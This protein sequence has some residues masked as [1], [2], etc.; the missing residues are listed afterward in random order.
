MPT[1]IFT[2]PSP[3]SIPIFGDSLLQL[4]DQSD[5]RPIHDL[6]TLNQG[7]VIE[8]SMG[9]PKPTEKT[10]TSFI[11]T[12]LDKDSNAII[13]QPSPFGSTLSIDSGLEDSWTVGETKH[14]KVRVDQ[15]GSSFPTS[16]VIYNLL[17]MASGGPVILQ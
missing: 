4:A 2:I 1:N 17:V 3:P 13:P 16:F 9:F 12:L 15:G 7:Q 5:A 8:I 6:G 14:Y 10:P 11:L